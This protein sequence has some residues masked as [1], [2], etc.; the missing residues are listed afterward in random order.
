MQDDMADGEVT[1]ERKL[2]TDKV[3]IL[4]R[5][6]IKKQIPRGEVCKQ[7]SCCGIAI[8]PDGN[9]EYNVCLPAALSLVPVDTAK[10]ET[11]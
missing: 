2:G 9:N 5:E 7:E 11:P 4:T 6:W 3:P 10:P 1:K 8:N